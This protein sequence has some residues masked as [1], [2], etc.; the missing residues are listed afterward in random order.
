[1]PPPSVFYFILSLP[2]LQPELVI[3][4]DF[5]ALRLKRYNYSILTDAKSLFGGTIRAMTVYALGG[6]N[7]FM[8]MFMIKAFF[9][10]KLKSSNRFLYRRFICSHCVLDEWNE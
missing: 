7:I 9:P 6:K 8:E 4:S 1:M 10:L 2:Q 3:I 5:N